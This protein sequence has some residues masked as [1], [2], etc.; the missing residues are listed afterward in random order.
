MAGFREII[1]KEIEAKKEQESRNKDEDTLMKE[2]LAI[3]SF[4]VGPSLLSNEV[5]QIF[6]EHAANLEQQGLSIKMYLE[7]VKKSEE[8]YKE[9]VVRPE[10]E[11]RLKAELLLR[12]IREIRGTEAT[13]EE[14]NS[15][16]EKVIAMYTSE[17]VVKR[18]R[19]KLVPG[20]TYYE[21]IK[22]RVTYRKIVDSF[23][24]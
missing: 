8:S 6:R 13:V 19:E 21:D 18:L 11:R 22:N 5:D 17:D 4:D 20:D 14:I 15:E 23:W 7:H 2:I 1:K 24:A 3:A 9:E 12:K 16:I 10:A